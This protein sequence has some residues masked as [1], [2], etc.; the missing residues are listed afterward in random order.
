MSRA[1]LSLF[2]S[3]QLTLHKFTRWF[4]KTNITLTRIFNLP[5][6][7][8][9]AISVRLHHHST[10]RPKLGS[11]SSNFDTPLR[12]A[13]LIRN[14]TGKFWNS[15]P[16]GIRWDGPLNS[17][18]RVF[19]RK[20]NEKGWTIRNLGEAD[21]AE[22]EG[23]GEEEDDVMVTPPKSKGKEK[24]ASLV[25]S[26]REPVLSRGKPSHS[27]IGSLSSP[28]ARLFGARAIPT[29]DQSSI[30]GGGGGGGNH[31]SNNLVA[32]TS[33]PF[34]GDIAAGGTKGKKQ[35]D[36]DSKILLER[37]DKL[38]EMLAV[39][40]RGELARSSAEE[41]LVRPPLR[42]LTGENEE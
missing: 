7:V 20:V 25:P 12:A 34:L 9:L 1:S 27:R 17:V 18:G 14:E 42:S 30:L 21:S 31:D 39:L 24:R 13:A 35:D 5:I 2:S 36:E 22:G 16:P 33:F 3:L 15:L 23:E 6:L 19:E 10:S 40:V 26:I 11:S 8:Y 37:L 28:L 38:E 32:S 29:D 41:A 4:H